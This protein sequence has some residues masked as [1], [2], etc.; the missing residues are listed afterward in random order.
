MIEVQGKNVVM[1]KMGDEKE[2]DYGMMVHKG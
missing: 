1:G 2:E